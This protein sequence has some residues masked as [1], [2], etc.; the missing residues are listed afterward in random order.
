MSK[1]KPLKPGQIAPHSGQYEV[2]GPRGG[3]RGHEVTSV[4]GERLPPTQNPGERY[5]LVDRTKHKG[6]K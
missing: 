3:K 1:S 6:K 2:V 5:V 4:E